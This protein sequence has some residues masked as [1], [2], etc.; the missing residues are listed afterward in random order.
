ME[1]KLSPT[2]RKPEVDVQLDRLAAAARRKVL[3]SIAK[4]RKL[5][6]N[7]RGDL[8]KHGDPE[9]WK[10]Y[11]DLLLAN[12]GNAVRRGDAVVVTDYFDEAVPTIEIEG[13]ENLSISEI[14]E[15]YFRRYTKARNGIGVIGERIAKAERAIGANEAILRQ[16]DAAVEAADIEFLT[17]FTEPAGQKAPIGRKKKAEAAFKG[18]RRFTSSDGLM[19]F[20]GKKATDNDYLT[21][22]LARSLDTWL[23]AADYPGSHVIVRNPNRGEIPNRTLTEAAQLAAFYSDA[24]KQPKA[25]VHYTHKKFVNKPR[26][27]APGLVSLASFRTILVEPKIGNVSQIK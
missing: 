21:F 11:G 4:D 6:A 9:Q 5:I 26:R 13:E 19:I 27:S 20:V 3:R 2:K 17:S 15:N 12:V 10:R 1:S 8:E 16:I 25:A 14:A 24:R 23:H 18:A 22:R 7:L